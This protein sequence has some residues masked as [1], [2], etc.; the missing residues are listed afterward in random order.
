MPAPVTSATT[1]G[2]RAE[3]ALARPFQGRV[4][5]TTRRF[6]SWTEAAAPCA[7][8]AHPLRCRRP[9]LWPDLAIPVGG[10]I[11]PSSSDR[12][13]RRPCLEISPCVSIAPCASISGCASTSRRSFSL[14]GVALEA[15][16][17]PR[18]D[19]TLQ[20]SLARSSLQP[21]TRQTSGAVLCFLSASKPRPLLLRVSRHGAARIER[22]PLRRRRLP[23]R[24]RSAEAPQ[25]TPDSIPLSAR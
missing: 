5:I 9:A 2:D 18:S 10:T 25:S 1:P 16:H 24:S 7:L 14:D 20:R 3:S 17:C 8:C 13:S 6:E 15:R 21:A 12:A 22:C 23:Q 4:A 19:S 11:R